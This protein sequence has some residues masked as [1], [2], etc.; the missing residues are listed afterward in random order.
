MNTQSK[1]TYW[2]MA[3]LFIFSPLSL[4]SQSPP[5]LLCDDSKTIT[6]QTHGNLFAVYTIPETSTLAISVRGADGGSIIT[7]GSCPNTSGGSGAMVNATYKVSYQLQRALRPGGT[8]LA[9]VGHRGLNADPR[10]S[11]LFSS[12]GGGGGSSA[13]LYLPPGADANGQNWHVLAVAGGG[14]GAT[15]AGPDVTLHVGKGA[16]EGG[17]GGN[18]GSKNGG[19]EDTCPD[20]GSGG[21]GGG[22]DCYS[23]SNANGWT[24]AESITGNHT[25]IAPVVKLR[26]F[27][28]QNIINTAGTNQ[29]YPNGGFGFH[30]GGAGNISAGGG[31]GG[32]YGGTTKIHHGGGG[33]GSFISTSFGA[34]DRNISKTPGKDGGANSITGKITI[35]TTSSA[36]AICHPFVEVELDVDG[37]GQLQAS[38]VDNGSSDVC[39]FKEMSLDKTILNCSDK[40]VTLTVKGVNGN[41]SSCTAEVKFIDNQP[42]VI[43]CKNV[44]IYLDENGQASVV[45]SDFD[46]GSYDA[47]G[48]VEIS[49]SD[50]REKIDVSCDRSNIIQTISIL[51]T[52]ESGNT[53]SCVR[54]LVVDDITPPTAICKDVTLSLSETGTASLEPQQVDMGSSDNCGIEEMTLDKTLVSCADNTVTLTVKDKSGNE[55]SCTAE[56]KFEN[57]IDKAPPVAIC[58]NI[59]VGLGENGRAS[60]VPSDFDNGSYDACGGVEIS[61]FNGKEEIVFFCERIVLTYNVPILVT[62]ESGNTSSCVGRVTV[63]DGRAPT[64]ICKNITLP[65]SESG[66]VS[67]SPSMIN[68]G[69]FDNC[70]FAFVKNWQPSILTCEDIGTF[71][72][73]MLVEDFNGNVGGCFGNVTIVDDLAPVAR[74]QDLITVELDESGTASLEPQQVDMGSSDNC[75]IEEM[76]LD[77]TLINCSDKTVTLTVKDKS[78]N[79][80]SCTADVKFENFIDNDPPVAICKNINVVVD[81]NGRASV[82]PYSFDNG[83][84]DAC[85]EV[86]ISF[87]DGKEKIDFSCERVDLTYDLT[88]LVTDESGN[89]SSCVGRVRVI[90]ARAP[91][92][93]CKNIT[94][95]L[96]ESGTV[97]FNPRMINNGSF[98]NCTFAAVINWQPSILTCEDIG[99]FEVLMLVEDWNGNVGGCFGNVT[100]V[101]DLAPVARCQEVTV[102]LN[103][104]GTA[105]LEPQQVNLGSSDNCGIEGMSLDITSFDCSSLGMH[106]VKLTV[107]DKSGNSHSC[108]ANIIVEEGVLP[109]PDITS[110]P[111]IEAECSAVINAPTATDNCAGTIV[112][113]SGDLSKISTPGTHLITWKYDDGNGN[114]ATQTQT[115]II[116]DEIKPIPDVA[117]LPTIR[118]ECS[119]TVSSAP[120]ASDNCSGTITGTTNDPLVYNSQGTHTITWTF[121]DG[122][123]NS[124]SQTQTV[125]VEDVTKPVPDL[126]TLPTVTGECSATVSTV[127]TANDNCTGQTIIGTTSDPLTYSTQGTH[128]ITWTFDDGNG[129]SISQTQTVIVDDVTAPV[130]DA[131][132]LPTVTGECAASLSQTPTATDNCE[133]TIIGTTNDPLSYASQGTHTVTWTFDDGNGNVSTQTQTVIIKDIT[134]PVPDLATLPTITGNCEAGLEPPF[135]TDNCEGQVIGTTFDPLYFDKEGAYTVTWVYD[136]GNGNTSSQDQTIIIED[137][138]APVPDRNNLPTLRA[139]CGLTVSTKPTATDRCVGTVIGTTTDPLTYNTQGIYLITWNFDDGNGNTSS[140]T[141]RVVIRDT[142][143]PVP[144]QANLPTLTGSCSVM[145]TNFPTATDNCAGSVT[146]TTDSPLEFDQEGTYAIL[147]NYDDGN[148]NTSIQTQWVIV[149]GDAAPNALCKNISIPMQSSGLVNIKAVDIDNGSFDD[150]GS[151][152]LLISP[153]GSIFGSSL[154]P[155]SN[156]DIHCVKG[157]VQNLLLS[158]TNEKGNTAYCQAKVTLEGM[159]SDNDGLLDSCDNCPDTYNPNQKDSNN[160]GKGDACEEDSNPNPNPGGWGGWS[161]KK[162]GQENNN[163]I[164]KLN[165]F[166]NPFQEEINL[167][168]NLNQE[169]KATIE[170]FNIHGQRVHTLLS[171]VAPKGE[172]RVLWDG[173]DQNGQPMPAG[174]YLVRLRAGKVL[175]NKKVMLQR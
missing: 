112:G 67:F 14:G 26:P 174:I 87:L 68:N 173:K 12:S 164:T 104:S 70:T 20:D 31:G 80:S 49:F 123:G 13:V 136:D 102:Q 62:D 15:N 85:G 101:D 88:I 7:K 17:D 18:V 115:V 4:I 98:D 29:N 41:E 42:P 86:Q 156:M 6:P 38:D 93:I 103:E 140:Q 79:E 150:C 107:Q 54:T 9:F 144:D 129:N 119:A 148:G 137:D 61:F 19:R 95:P 63:R 100:I 135:A 39:G 124:I 5:T 43:I 153:A 92:A 33:G 128:T 155:T 69:S 44:R 151:V 83:S 25:T 47:C 168:F 142:K 118:G 53:S 78:G 89:T 127:P 36:Q 21:E 66:T 160:N 132:S 105:S 108:E 111:D 110:L 114:V 159:D 65:L 37:I 165:A 122:N 116:K 77:K 1:T 162:Q 117:S 74:C 2:L 52:D 3:C 59:N 141:Q 32:F 138:I 40:T 82:T 75:G 96:S 146:A 23:Q 131:A 11:N 120:T 139:Q 30:G 147:W 126:S 22:F 97:S 84:F 149:G 163:L 152:T 72:A 145:I 16:K 35:T 28:Y 45:P 27:T 121:D 133:G 58:K 134:A 171:E 94:L 130:P 172:H 50:G 99:T 73:L 166:P 113:T 60:V 10:C 125:I 158:V 55:S 64:A 48:G 143:A 57:F 34:D 169:E 46:N 81:E 167:S 56:V 109:V 161:L 76:T 175:I 51:V 170:I 90:D 71:E 154:S 91:T 157:K 24:M 8:I 106:T